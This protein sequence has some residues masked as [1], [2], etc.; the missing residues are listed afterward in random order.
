MT[1]CRPADPSWKVAAL[2]LVIAGAWFTVSV[3]LCVPFGVTPPFD[4]VIV[5]GNVP[6]GPVG[7]PERVAVPVPVVAESERPAGS[8]VVVMLVAVGVALVVIVKVPAV[9]T[10]NV[11]LL[12]LVIATARLAWYTD[13][14]ATPVPAPTPLA[15]AVYRPGW[16]VAMIA[17]SR[18]SLGCSPFACSAATSAGLAL[19]RPSSFVAVTGRSAMRP[20]GRAGL[21]HRVW[22][23]PAREGP[24]PV[25][26]TRFGLGG[27]TRKP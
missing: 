20:Q 12:A 21:C 8:A 3:K 11:A 18:G 27:A 4:A 26:H 2:A 9:P 10:V 14:T 15:T 23:R 25:D 24:A 13:T 1:V 6:P 17:G 22:A 7:V 19:T 5:I 16:S